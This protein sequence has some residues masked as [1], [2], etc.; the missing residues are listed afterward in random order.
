MTVVLPF[1][2]IVIPVLDE[3]RHVGDVLA[4]LL[5]Q[6]RDRNA[7]ILVMDGGSR[8][9][10]RAIVEAISVHDPSVRLIDNPG[11]TQSAACNLAAELVSPKSTIL[12]R[13]DAHAAYPPDFVVLTI[14]A[15]QASGATSVVVPMRTVGSGVQQRAIA[16]AQNSRLGNGGSSHRRAGMSRFVDHG[17]HAAFWLPFFRSI[18]GYDCSFTHNEDA[19]FDVRG[20]RAGGRVWLCGEAAIAY[21]PRDSLSSLAR[22]YVRHGRGRAR[23]IYKHRLRPKLRQSLPLVLLAAVAAGLLAPVVPWLGVPAAIY[24]GASVLWGAAAAVRRRDP[25]LLLM[26]L[27]AMVMHLAW[28]IGFLDGGRRFLITRQVR[29]MIPLDNIKPVQAN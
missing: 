8:D 18:G 21:F 11:R 20:H 12:L 1:F 13:A 4:S 25:A 29:P 23:T 15:L 7:E 3:E 26:G 19:E 2:S 22:Q 27:A 14:Q 17:H 9:A 24:L 6:V 10:T 28:A 5:A 16:A